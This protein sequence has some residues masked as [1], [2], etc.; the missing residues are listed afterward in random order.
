M[1]IKIRKLQRSFLNTGTATAWDP[2][3]NGTVLDL[4]AGGS[5]VYASGYFTGIGGQTRNRI[6]ALDGVTGAATSWN[7]DPNA[8]VRA[9]VVTGSTVY[10]GGEFTSI[11]GQARHH[12]AA[13]DA[14]M[15]AARDWDP[16]PGPNPTDY[17]LV[18]AASGT[19][20]FVGGDFETMGGFPNHGIAG[21]RRTSVPVCSVV[22]VTLDFGTVPLGTQPELS[23]EIQ[24]VGAWDCS[25]F[26]GLVSESCPEFS[27]TAGGGYYFLSS[28]DS[29][30]VTV[31]F[32]PSAEGVQNCTVDTGSSYCGDVAATGNAFL[33][34]PICSVSPDSVDFGPVPLGHS[35]DKTIVIR[36]TSPLIS[37]PLSGQVQESSSDY[38]I[39]SGGDPFS[40]AA[41]DS[42]SV[43][44]RFNPTSE[45][46][47]PCTI[48]TGSPFCSAIECT[49]AGTAF[50]LAAELPG[51]SRGD[52]AWGDYDG[53]GDLDLILAGSASTG[54]VCRVYRNDAGT[55]TQMDAGLP[56][57]WKC[58][59]AWGDYDGDGD[60]DI[61]LAGDTGSGRLSRVY[62]NDAGIFTDIGAGLP[63]V[64]TCAV[65][66]G[67]YDGDGDLDILLAGDTGSER[68][69]RVY[70]NNA[71]T[72]ADAGAGLPGVA[73]CAVAWG[74]Y[75][76]DKDLDILLTGDTGAEH[77]SRV[78]RN[79]GGVFTDIAAGLLGVA[80]SAVAWGDYDSDG[81]LDIL[82][83]GATTTAEATRI[84][85]NDTGTFVSASAGLPS[86]YDGG[87]GWGDYD[88]DGD[89]DVLAAGAYDS[90]HQRSYVYRNDAGA[91]V[92]ATAGFPALASASVR[93]G[94]Y[95]NDGRLDVFLMGNDFTPGRAARIYRNVQP[96]PNTAPG[97]PTSPSEHLVSSVATLQWLAADDAET[98]AAGLTYNVRVGTTP[99]GS[100]IR[101]AMS[102]ML[103][104]FRRIV[105]IGNADHRAACTIALPDTG[106]YYWSVQAVD[107]SFA[108][109]PFVA[110]RAMTLSSICDVEP[111]TLD[112]GSVSVGAFADRSFVIRN[113]Q[114]QAISG[115]VGESCSDYSIL[116]GAGDYT[117]AAGDSVTVVIRFA[118]SQVARVGCGIQTGASLCGIVGCTGLGISPF[119]GVGAGLVAT[120]PVDWG[121]YGNDGDLDIIAYGTVGPNFKPQLYLNNEGTFA[122]GG[123]FSANGRPIVWGDYDRDGDLDILAGGYIF[124][125]DGPAFV[126]VSS[127]LPTTVSPSAGGEAWGDY[128]ND[129]DLDVLVTGSTGISTRTSRVY[130][131]DN[132]SFTDVGAGLPAVEKSAVDWGDFDNDGDLDFVLAGYTGSTRITRIYRNDSGVFTD[133]GAGLTGVS[134]CAA[135]WGD[136]D[137]D[138]D[139][140]LA[141]SGFTGSTYKSL[142]YRNDGG[143]FT[144]IN[145]ALT[146]MHYSS[147]AWG[148]YDNDGDLDLILAGELVSSTTYIYRNGNGQFTDARAG[149]PG[150]SEGDV[151]WGDY[152]KDGDLD[153][154]LA[155]GGVCN[156]YRNN[157]VATN[158]P[159]TAPGNL[160]ATVSGTVA[161]L[162]WSA[163]SDDHTPSPGLTYNIRV[164][165]AP[166]GC[167]I[168]SAM[169]HAEDG[170]RRVARM[171][172]AQ[173]N[174]SWKVSL[175]G[176]GA[177]YWS[178]QAVDGAFAGSAFAPT[179][180]LSTSSAM[181][182]VGD[183]NGWDPN[184]PEMTTASPGTWADTLEIAAG[185]HLLK[186]RTNHDG[187][188]DY[189]GCAGEDPGCLAPMAGSICPTAGSGTSVGYVAFPGTA[190]YVFEVNELASTYA[191]WTLGTVGMEPRSAPTAFRIRPATPNPFAEQT[192]LSY[193]L[194]ERAAIAIRLF[195]VSGRLVKVLEDAERGPGVYAV[196]W[197][198][199]DAAGNRAP[200]GIYYAQIHVGGGNAGRWMMLRH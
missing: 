168:V 166:G 193:E 38:S 69:C 5:L 17:A 79:D 156:L 133:I 80:L 22:P 50:E 188:P 155:G 1:L 70:R 162:H 134:E 11:G 41:G 34:D 126:R 58:A 163:S 83:C 200:A 164:A 64:S 154:L 51:V 48:T 85:R 54:K 114:G 71:G 99:G 92:D 157:I 9:V 190:M 49:G 52:A 65:A 123:P 145:A 153:I 10:A 42:V 124:R 57:V 109:S 53:D 26:P 100:Q 176:P 95:D 112:F 7:P 111:T 127:G 3:A 23:F 177:Y 96:T 160:W 105:E 2:N 110:E 101:S 82:L 8:V 19:G 187:D 173:H 60:L 118:P 29:R 115:S 56:G 128:D 15:G 130:R 27:L 199:R 89:L 102:D 198:G 135:V 129:G 32:S 148:D 36:N 141:I 94:D 138:G 16:N 46:Q 178:V 143:V 170:Y 68:M 31:R 149:L 117:L 142:I 28:G 116:S 14:G 195:D 181:Q 125:N 39:V 158:T 161:T 136:Y 194:P 186:F 140:D 139:L 35:S 61:L 81:D 121:D 73:D 180:V 189:G 144:D 66:W 132:G 91:F 106:T 84:Y 167:D 174:L 40:L 104:G 98:P 76:H 44:V 87:L 25:E 122:N 30:V 97:L 74:D 4:A 182:I 62:R 77:I 20:I 137:S 184:A 171:G 55:F 196:S 47:H 75:D 146:G 63:G 13:L 12:V 172:N 37:H 90:L 67:D 152:D 72:F 45:G 103:T 192:S 107:G 6:A 120:S 21:F 93:W 175:P 18:M 151:H 24:N 86:V 119:T 179:Q 165:T 191:I 185:C 169:A 59:V 131:N 78:Y 43:V 33:S 147:A 113:S 88:N 108:G 159:P 183:F 197:D 150:V